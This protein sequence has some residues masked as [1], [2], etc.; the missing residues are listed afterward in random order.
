[1]Q[2]NSTMRAGTRTI[3]DNGWG[4][5]T[6]IELK[7]YPQSG[8]EGVHYKKQISVSDLSLL[9][10]DPARVDVVDR[11]SLCPVRNWLQSGFSSVCL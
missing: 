5:Q 1:M 10:A 9:V 7:C 8:A 6:L 2:E 11:R 4:L 3:V